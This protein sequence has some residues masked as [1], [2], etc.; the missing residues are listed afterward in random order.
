MQLPIKV[1]ARAMV[2]P[3]SMRVQF[4]ACNHEFLADS[5]SFICHVERLKL[6][7]WWMIVHYLQGLQ[8]YS[9][10][11]AELNSEH[12]TSLH[13]SSTNYRRWKADRAWNEA[14]VWTNWA[15]R[16]WSARTATYRS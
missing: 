6:E 4:L 7:D 5:S 12:L 9:S 10:Y 3:G 13:C 16:T 15:I 2:H 1:K 8:C 11:T 14:R